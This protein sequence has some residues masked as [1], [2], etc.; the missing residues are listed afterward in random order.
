MSIV[1]R[2]TTGLAAVL[3]FGTSVYAKSFDVDD[4]GV[5]FNLPLGYSFAQCTT[6][7]GT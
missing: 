2:V 7:G 1:F 4:A 3:F 6:G 5:K